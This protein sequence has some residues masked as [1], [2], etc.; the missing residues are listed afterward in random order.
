MKTWHTDLVDVYEV[1]FD[2]DLHA[3]N[4]TTADGILI[5]T[6]YPD[7]IEDMQNLIDEL[8]AGGCPIADRWEDGRGNICSLDGWG[9]HR[10]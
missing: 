3:F 5:G 9:P 10:R 1:P 6:V 2:Y 4:V 8:D 7:T